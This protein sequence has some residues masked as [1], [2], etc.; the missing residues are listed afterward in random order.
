MEA[1]NTAK[2][3]SQSPEQTDIAIEKRPLPYIGVDK[4][5]PEPEEENDIVFHLPRTKRFG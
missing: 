1:R 5:T 4:P 3:V 2:R